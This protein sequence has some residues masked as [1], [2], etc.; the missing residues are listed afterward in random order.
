RYSIRAV[1]VS[2]QKFVRDAKRAKE[3]TSSLA[4]EAL[5]HPQKREEFRRQAAIQRENY[6][7]LQREAA[8]FQ[9]DIARIRNQV[10]AIGNN[11]LSAILPIPNENIK[12]NE[13][14]KRY[15]RIL[16]RLQAIQM[17]AVNSHVPDEDNKNDSKSDN[18]ENFPNDYRPLDGPSNRCIGE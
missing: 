11:N 7:I 14:A 16:T 6:Q 17:K 10:I 18:K 8:A 13:T 1:I 12:A 5:K 2:G 3:L 9:A 4:A 15:G